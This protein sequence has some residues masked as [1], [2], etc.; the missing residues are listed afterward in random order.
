[1]WRDES[2]A[3][4]NFN[5]GAA[6]VHC[7]PNWPDRGAI[8]TA[9][10]VEWGMW[11]LGIGPGTAVFDRAVLPTMRKG[12]RAVRAALAWRRG[13]VAMAS[14]S[15][16]PA[17]APPGAD[18]ARAFA[19]RRAQMVALMNRHCDRVLC[20]SDRVR[21]IALAHG[22]DPA[23]AVTSYIGSAQ[24]SNWSRTEPRPQF[25]RPDGT[26]RLAYLGYMRADKGFPFLLDALSALPHALSARLHL[27]VAARR[28]DAAQM[29]AMNAL[30]P[31]LAGLRHVD[32]YSHDDL[33]TLLAGVDLGLV[34]VMWEDN[35]PQV[36]LEMHARHIPI[37]CSDRGGAQE[38]GNCSAL[39]HRAGDTDDFARALEGV[40]SGRVTPAEYWCAARP[41]TS[42]ADH[43]AEVLHHYRATA[44]G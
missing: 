31:R 11:R 34:P 28:G 26:L 43:L 27:T 42:M 21:Q 39:V 37:L 3:C 10:A 44:A 30:R 18:R 6:C 8:R 23:R 20:V 35:L 32:G 7:L 19:D 41:P 38:L 25:L 17:L 5:H 16:A 22:I 29:A 12:W 1:L 4:T 13:P 9:Y 15:V 2:R 40:L 24:A 36:A 14:A 33:D